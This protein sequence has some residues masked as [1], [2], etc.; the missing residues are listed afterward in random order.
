MYTKVP[1]SLNF[2]D[3]EKE[4]LQ[5]W[6][7]NHIFEKSCELR[8]GRP[9]Y[10]FYDGP[11][12]A[13]GKPHIGHILTR[14][15]KDIIPRYRT[16][17][18]YDVL[19]KA[20]WDTHGLPVELEVEK[21]LGLDGK[22]QIEAY[23]VEPFIAKCKESVWKYKTEWEQ[24]SDRVGYWA[25]MEHP[26]VTYEDNYIESEWWALKTIYEKGLLYKG[27]KVVPYCPRCGTALASHEV[28]QGYKDV[29]EI[30]ATVRFKCTDEDASYLAWTTTPW[31]LPSNVCLCVN[32][33]IV[34]C[35]AEKDG[36]AFILAK[37]L[38]EKVLG[39]DAKIVREFAGS[40]LVGRTYEPLFE[41][42]AKAAAKTGKKGFRITTF[43]L[44][45][46]WTPAAT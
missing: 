17:K 42:T 24:M 14:A 2:V 3:R 38:V 40:E 9:A 20:G 8:K 15:M 29:K 22:K 11:P 36:E 12:T 27:H 35:R 5:F 1:T 13:N 45:R 46:W 44:V 21:M 28:A 43:P 31:T 18:G 41:C 32:A 4:I 37:D 7:E 34:Y 10:T 39:E 19:R 23:G 26:Y 25:D 30:S 16:M 6:K 33:D